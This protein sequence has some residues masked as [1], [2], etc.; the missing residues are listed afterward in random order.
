MTKKLNRLLKYLSTGPR[1]I[2]LMRF[3]LIPIH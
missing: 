3:S 2:A 1:Q